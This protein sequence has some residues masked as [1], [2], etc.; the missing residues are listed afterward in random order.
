MFLPSGSVNY[1]NQSSS[2]SL[3]YL[4]TSGKAIIKVDNTSN[5]S[6]Y[7][8]LEKRN[9][10]GSPFHLV[11]PRHHSDSQPP[12][13]PDHDQRFLQHGD[14]LGHRCRP[15]SVRLF[16]KSASIEFVECADICVLVGLAEHMDERKRLAE[17][18]RDRHHRRHQHHDVQPNG[19]AH[20]QGLHGGVWH[21]SD[22]AAHWVRLQ[23]HCRMYC[24][25]Y[26]PTLWYMGVRT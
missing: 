26:F 2:A 10:V 17:Q 16:S 5:V 9:S 1:V 24:G 14:G 4:D 21:R 23:F 13:G 8:Y 7:P 12:P 22:W 3:T 11:N 19:V 6:T 18:R 15:P 25:E 20:Q